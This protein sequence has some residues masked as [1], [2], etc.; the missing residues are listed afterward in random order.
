MECDIFLLSDTAQVQGD[1]LYVL[2]GGFRFVQAPALPLSHQFAISAGLLVDWRETNQQHDFRIDVKHDDTGDTHFSVVGSFEQGQPPGHPA[3]MAQRVLMSF[4]ASV[5]LEAAGPH[6]V[7]ILVDN[8]HLNKTTFVVRDL[9]MPFAQAHDPE[10]KR[11]T[12]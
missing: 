4:T 6:T 12:E 11:P 8:Q 2:G 10:G 7:R 5:T 9:S 3:G 1:K